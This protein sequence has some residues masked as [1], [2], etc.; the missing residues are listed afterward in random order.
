ME[1]IEHSA[2]LLLEKTI[3]SSLSGSEGDKQRLFMLQY[4]AIIEKHIFIH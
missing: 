1:T 2:K 3:K 4:C